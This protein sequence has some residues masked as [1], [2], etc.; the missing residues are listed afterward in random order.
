MRGQPHQYPPD[1]ARYARLPHVSDPESR[2]RSDGNGRVAGMYL[3]TVNTSYRY[4]QDARTA[5]ARRA[6][7]P[8]RGT[9]PLDTGETSRGCPGDQGRGPVTAGDPARPRA[10]LGTRHV[11]RRSMRSSEP[12]WACPRLAEGGSSLAFPRRHR[13]HPR[14]LTQPQRTAFPLTR[15]SQFDPR[16][17]AR[18]VV[19]TQ[20]RACPRWVGVC[21]CFGSS[22][23]MANGN[24]NTPTKISG[25]R[26][27]S[28]SYPFQGEAARSSGGGRLPPTTLSRGIGTRAVVGPLNLGPRAERHIHPARW[29]ARP[30][31]TALTTLWP[32]RPRTVMSATFRA[33]RCPPCNTSIS[34]LAHPRV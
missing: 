7:A 16:A 9:K 25:I 14:N 12:P 23:A 34:A 26:S 18:W 15:D 10:S 3:S 1:E 28:T 11:P 33:Q 2:C 8:A 21:V 6:A 24:R 22:H 17:S 29:D 32:V 5:H 4:D 31:G 27:R 19:A 30:S 13:A 20:R